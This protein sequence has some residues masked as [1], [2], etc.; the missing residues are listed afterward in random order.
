MSVEASLISLHSSKRWV[1]TLGRFRDLA[2]K[3]TQPTG[4]TAHTEGEK[5][6]PRG[7]HYSMC[8]VV[9]SLLVLRSGDNSKRVPT[10]TFDYLMFLKKQNRTEVLCHVDYPLLLLTP[11]C[12]LFSRLFRSFRFINKST[13]NL[14]RRRL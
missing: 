1:F 2:H 9:F 8:M 5:Y 7:T 6:G 10:T 14:L 3:R 4:N 13:N 11:T 12:S